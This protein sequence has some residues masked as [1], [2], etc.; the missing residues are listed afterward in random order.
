ML[1]EDKPNPGGTIPSL[2]ADAIKGKKDRKSSPAST[3]R[4]TASEA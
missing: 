2:S 3:L 1:R 4:L